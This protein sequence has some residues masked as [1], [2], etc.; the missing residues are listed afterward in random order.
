M[1]ND[2]V[3]NLLNST[4]AGKITKNLSAKQQNQTD[5]IKADIWNEFIEKIKTGKTVKTGISL[6]NAMNS[7]TKYA[8]IEAQKQNKSANDVAKEWFNLMGLELGD[9]KPE[10]VSAETE[11]AAQPEPARTQPEIDADCERAV[12]DENGIWTVNEYDTS[13]RLIK[14]THYEPD[15]T[16]IDYTEDFIPETGNVEKLTQY[17]GDRVDFVNTNDQDGNW[18]KQESY[19]PDG[20]LKAYK[21]YDNGKVVYKLNFAEDGVTVINAE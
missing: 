10:E 16:H 4:L 19:R 20:T 18:I 14:S 5:V 17:S 8:V 13:D 1:G 9:T 3:E 15:G 21:E 12:C 2:R 11:Q 6:E 7:I